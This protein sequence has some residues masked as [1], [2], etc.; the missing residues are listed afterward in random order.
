MRL[1]FLV[2]VGALAALLAPAVALAAPTS[3]I[4]LKADVVDYYSNRFILT[5]DGGVRAQLSD[6]TIVTG[7]SFAMDLK[8]NR[9]LIAG[10]VH[11]DGPHV[12]EQGA[13]FAGYPDLDRSY[14]LTEADTPDRWTYYGLDFTDKHVG[15][16]HPG[17]AF[18]FPDLTS[19]KP[20]IR[21]N[22]ATIFPK[23]N[24]EFPAG[25]RISILGV[26]TITP[27]YVVNFS[28]NSNF[29]QNAFSGATFDIGVPYHGAAD[30]ISAG[31]IRYDNTRGF[32]A[33]FD[34]HV[35]H[36]ADY[37][38]LSLNPI[39]QRQRQWN[40]VGYKRESAAFETRLFFQLSTTSEGIFARPKDSSS[41]ANLTVNSR[42]GR[43]GA[44]L[45]FDQFNNSLLNTANSGI[46]PY[47]LR[48]DGHPSD[49][50]F[51]LQSFENELRLGRSIGV[52]IKF[53]YRGGYGFAHDG[54]SILAV[55]GSFAWGGVPY[56]TIF[57]KF[58]GATVYT[59][60]IKLIR[61]T[62]ISVKADKQRQWYSLPHHVDTTNASVTLANTPLSPKLPAL[63]LAYNV[64]NVGD[65]YGKDQLAAYAP[66]ADVA[67][68]PFGTYTGLAAFR[69]FATSHSYTGSIAY[70]P[71]QYFGLNLTLQRSYVNPAPIPGLGGAPPWAFTGDV[72]I[73][74]ARTVLVDLSRSYYFNFG[75]QRWTPQFGIQFSP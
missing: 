56:T 9:F 51:S 33:S 63:L 27:G 62:T 57:Q 40:F 67:T 73:R 20:Y 32:Y 53:Q 39:T 4:L 3:S 34:Q 6:G 48:V 15:R 75:N 12:H 41:F 24:V 71:T 69:G 52:P 74:L 17:D 28:S 55:N 70:T 61:Q 5:G 31:H 43:Y 37:A 35:V 18:F 30:A 54:F 46:T 8:L 49:F 72:R 42:I 7:N 59:P 29:Y 66:S 19:E 13:A 22:A 65:Y 45:N 14:F 25:S 11:L 36:N 2:L 64:I 1:F 16:E 44:S 50:Q 47:G 68:T 38:V 23:N 58:V 21:S 26:Y 60:S 10:N